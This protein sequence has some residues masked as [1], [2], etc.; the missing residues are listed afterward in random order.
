MSAFW[1]EELDDLRSRG[2]ARRLR[3]RDEHGLIN[4]SSNDYLGL[5]THPD[6]VAAAARAL[7]SEGAGGASSRLLAGTGSSHAELEREL[8]TFLGREAALVFSSGY[9]VNTGVIP[10]LVGPQDSVFVD[11]LAHASI[12]DG[13]RL[14]GARLHTFAHNDMADLA[15][16]LSRYRA[17][18]RR[19]LAVTEGLFSMDGD[20][21][22][23][24]AFVRA[25]R[26][27]DAMTYLDDAHAIGVVGPAGRGSAAAAGLSE[28]I[29]IYVATL[30]K[31]LGTQ[32][33][34]VA[35]RT[36][37]IEWLVSRCRSFIFTTALAP[38][39]AAAGLAALRLLPALDDRRALLARAGDE[40]RVRL[41]RMGYSTLLS[42]SQIV[43]VW[44]GGVEEALAMAAHL[45][46]RG[47]FVPAIRPP[48]V[49]P[50]EC[51]LRLSLT[52][53]L[54]AGG[55]EPV[56]ESFYSYGNRPNPPGEKRVQAE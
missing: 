55:L 48:T 53:P 33:G 7:E 56:A 22:D 52:Y 47:L 20:A 30:S 51:R 40:L 10:A 11:R 37:L 25:A 34:L 4:L 49:A 45:E 18:R 17:G 42:R 46:E 8:A 31:A 54:A 21:P 3:R 9:H 14:S 44:A 26:A 32:G 15:D 13:V 50:G 43:P 29:D 2:L 23:L 5:A 1:E 39:C 35:G 6:V 38:A 27:H 12:I 41:V 24:P 16:Q 19:A 36:S 28:E